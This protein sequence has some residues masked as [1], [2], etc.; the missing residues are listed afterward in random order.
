MQHYSYF[1]TKAIATLGKICYN[2]LKII[3]I[4][5]NVAVKTRSMLSHIPFR[6]TPCFARSF[7]SLSQQL[8][9]QMP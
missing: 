8:I 6:C 5:V 3:G 9:R 2:N 7:Y 4:L 1:F